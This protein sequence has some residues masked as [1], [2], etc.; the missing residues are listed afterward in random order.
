MY[1][2]ICYKHV[3]IYIYIQRDNNNDNHHYKHNNDNDTNNH[4]NVNDSPRW[5]P[6]SR[7]R[8][9]ADLDCKLMQMYKFR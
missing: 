7:P 4:N 6:H 3:Y 9:P 8:P 1:I 5:T 2:H